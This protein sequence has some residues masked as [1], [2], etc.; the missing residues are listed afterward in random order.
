[1]PESVISKTHVIMDLAR[2]DIINHL[3]NFPGKF[4]FDFTRE[5]LERLSDDQL[6]HIL[7]A[8]YLHAQ[9]PAGH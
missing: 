5:Y 9:K 3:L 2:E 8:A 1:M 4:R 6:R 7:M